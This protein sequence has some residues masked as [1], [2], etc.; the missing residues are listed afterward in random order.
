MATMQNDLR[1]GNKGLE[2]MQAYL[3]NKL[4]KA[5]FNKAR[6]AAWAQMMKLPE[7]QALI[8][9]EQQKKVRTQRKLDETSALLQMNR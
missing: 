4:I 6:Y 8:K 1:T 3:H 7:V 9:A 2:P 5:E